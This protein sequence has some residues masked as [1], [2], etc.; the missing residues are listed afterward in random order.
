MIPR[1]NGIVVGMDE[2]GRG[3]WAGP[4]VAA[5]V[6]LPKGLKL[7]GLKD[8]KQV[9]AKAREKL[10]QLIVAA[11]P[12]GI[13][14]ATEIEVDEKGLLNA[15]YCAFQRALENLPTVPDQILI[16]GR[17]KF[18]F[19][20]PHLSIIRGDQKVPCISAASIL[21]KVSRDRMMVDYAK[22]YP[23]YGFELHK[24]Y[25]TEAHQRSLRQFGPC[26]LHRH[27]YKPLKALQCSQ[28]AF[29]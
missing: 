29:L 5:A 6:I 14:V 3:S 1:F 2:A 10:F 7:K 9:T 28:T 23:N 15:T 17:D 8:S 13:G 25:G 19:K 20:I 16:D 24:G 12:Y 18:S 27:S 21:A 26:D 22:T 4:V 11:C